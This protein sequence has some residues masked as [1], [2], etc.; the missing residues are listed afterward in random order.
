MRWRGGRR[1][2]NVEDRR[3]QG[4]AMG[5]AGAAPALLR[6]VPMLLRTKVGRII[7]IGGVVLIFGGQML[8]IDVLSLL[9]GGGAV[10]QQG[11]G[12]PNPQEQEVVEFV[13]VVEGGSSGDEASPAGLGPGIRSTS[14]G[15]SR[16]P[17]ER[18][19]SSASWGHSRPEPR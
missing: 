1:S 19:L 12:Q 14:P 13:S 18:L 8:G 6:F 15:V 10:Q 16:A 17:S 3:G 2:D 4:P 11:T 7:L 9:A 5:A